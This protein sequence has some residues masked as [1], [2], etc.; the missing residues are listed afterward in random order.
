MI[1]HN[2]LKEH[3]PDVFQMVQ[4]NKYTK[5]LL[6]Q[7]DNIWKKIDTYLQKEMKKQLGK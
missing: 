1:I 5:P 4:Q 2:L 6:K 7:M 3:K